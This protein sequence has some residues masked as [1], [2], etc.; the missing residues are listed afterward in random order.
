LYS[1]HGNTTLT[2]FST[3]ELILITEAGTGDLSTLIPY[4]T[5]GISPCYN[6]FITDAIAQSFRAKKMSY[7]NIKVTAYSGHRGNER[8]ASLIISDKT[9]TVVEIVD[10]WIEEN[11]LDRVRKRFFVVKA[12]DD[13]RYKIYEDEKTSEWFCEIR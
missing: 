10:K 8:P 1:I 4:V 12:N 13:Q 9:V 2:A 5:E 11:F 6:F 7:V 3:S